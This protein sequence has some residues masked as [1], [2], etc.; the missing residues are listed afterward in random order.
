MAFHLNV[1]GPVATTRRFPSTAA[2]LLGIRRQMRWTG[3]FGYFESPRMHVMSAVLTFLIGMTV[4]NLH[5][6]Q[7]GG[8]HQ[9]DMTPTGSIAPKSLPADAK[10]RSCE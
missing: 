9:Y 10:T 7:L 6:G 8:A 5:L 3:Q 1:R 4:A 2:Q